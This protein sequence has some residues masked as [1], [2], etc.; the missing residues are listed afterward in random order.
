MRGPLP[1]APNP[2][3][4]APGFR[5]PRGRRAEHRPLWMRGVHQGV[6]G[7]DYGGPCAKDVESTLGRR[8][9]RRTGRFR[10]SVGG[11]PLDKPGHKDQCCYFVEK[12]MGTLDGMAQE[13]SPR[14]GE[15]WTNVA[16]WPALPLLDL[17]PRKFPEQ[18]TAVFDPHWPKPLLFDVAC[19]TACSLPQRRSLCLLVPAFPAPHTNLAPTASS[20]LT[21]FL[22]L[23]MCG[24]SFVVGALLLRCW[25]GLFWVM[26]W[27]ARRRT[28]NQDGSERVLRPRGAGEC[29]AR[30]V[31]RGRRSIVFRDFSRRHSY[32]HA[33]Q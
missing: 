18:A 1:R 7:V 9:G 25:W 19:S 21:V 32:R 6:G 2:V 16:Q 27:D 17:L 14:P 28:A 20:Y 13:I 4:A 8:I 12:T 5:P 22:P 3:Q 31:S 24:L 33:L 11:V 15:M 23:N 10:S 30:P 26:P 29:R